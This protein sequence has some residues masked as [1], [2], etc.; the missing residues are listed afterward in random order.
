[1]TMSRVS[2]RPLAMERANNAAFQT[3]SAA[4]TIQN[5]RSSRGLAR[6]VGSIA[7]LASAAVNATGSASARA[8]RKPL[9]LRTIGTSKTGGAAVLR[10][11]LRDVDAGLTTS[12]IG[13]RSRLLFEPAAGL[14]HS[15]VAGLLQISE[16]LGIGAAGAVTALVH[17]PVV[18]AGGRESA[19]TRLAVLSDGEFVVFFGSLA[20]PVRIRELGAAAHPSLA[21]G[22]REQLEW[23]P[24]RQRPF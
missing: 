20:A 19:L 16:R 8:G 23:R 17:V 1:M 21:A 4:A 9:S 12:L 2:V 11:V 13:S 18:G 10:R 7:R 3:T 6:T 14:D 5:D 15:K 22:T 24:I